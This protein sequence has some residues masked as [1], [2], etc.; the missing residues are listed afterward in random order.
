VASETIQNY[1]LV[2][3][4]KGCDDAGFGDDNEHPVVDAGATTPLSSLGWQESPHGVV[5]F[6]EY[7][8]A[9]PDVGI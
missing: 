5:E 8:G 2:K 6:P 3:A 7:R 1:L 4:N 9:S